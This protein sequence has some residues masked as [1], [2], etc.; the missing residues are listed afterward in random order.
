VWGVMNTFKSI[1]GSNTVTLNA[2]APGI[3]EALITTAIGILISICAVFISDYVESIKKELVSKM[4]SFRLEFMSILSREMDEMSTINYNR[5]YNS[6][7][8]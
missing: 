1:A 4:E 6:K 5:Y 7:K 8:Q 2:I 3:G